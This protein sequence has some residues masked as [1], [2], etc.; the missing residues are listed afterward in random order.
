MKHIRAGSFV[1]C[2]LWCFAAIAACASGGANYP[3]QQPVPRVTTKSPSAEAAK[4]PEL[5]KPAQ[6]QALAAAAVP[7]KPRADIGNGITITEVGGVTT[8]NYPIQIGRPFVQGEIPNFPQAVIDGAPVLTQADVKVRWPDGSVKHAILNFFIPTLRSRSQVLITF[9][10][11][12][13][14]N[15]EGGL[16]KDAMLDPAYDFEAQMKLASESTS[17]AAS[18]RAMLEAGA[19]TTW[20]QGSVATS[21]ILADHSEKRAF[22]IGFDEHRSFRPIFHATFWPTIK[23]VRVRF[24]GEL[25]NTEV[26][27]DQTY[28]LELALGRKSPASVYSKPTFIQWAGSRWT[29]EFWIG[30]APSAIAIDHNLAY[31]VR[32]LM[33]PNYDLS[34]RIPERVLVNEYARWIKSSHDI[35]GSGNW[36]PRMGNAGARADIGPYPSW[37]VRW[38]YTG[39]S[40]MAEMAFG[41]AD[42]AATWPIHFREGKKGKFFDRAKKVPA[43]GKVLSITARPSIHLLTLTANHT[44]R[45]DK[46]TIVGT[47][48]RGDWVPENAHQPD[49]V[50]PQYMLSGDYW[51]LEELYFWAS[52]GAAFPNGAMV[53]S[54]CGRG[55]TG[56][57]GG[58]PGVG[59]G[60][61][62]AQ[63]WVI[64]TRAQTAS[65]APD[66]SPEKEYF[67]TLLSDFIAIAEGQRNITSTKFY[68][69]PNWKWGNTAGN[70]FEKV[71][72]SP[73]HFWENGSGAFVQGLDKT[74]AKS[75]ISTWEQNFM[76]F[77]LARA[78]DLGYPTEALVSWLAPN[79]IGQLTSS[80]YDPYLIGSNRTAT[81]N[82]EDGKPF[83]S[84]SEVRSAIPS[85]F[86]A[87]KDFM[88]RIKNAEHGYPLIA[89]AAVAAAAQEPGGAVAWKWIYD[90]A[91]LPEKSLLDANP[92]WAI[93]P[94]Q[95]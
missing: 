46:I 92:K 8:Q 38:L 35:R 2:V 24:I 1:S 32:T 13:S 55:P 73:L 26:F 42:L 71:G 41:N 28:S 79:I 63:A 82:R 77:A 52:F 20:F 21:I 48:K 14:G 86:D 93:L 39:D 72:P 19:Y 70:P 4:V 84:W 66:N 90:N 78:K 67:E 95:K 83:T 30:G 69:T 75:A 5:P 87:K 22:D 10:N 37:T 33:V 40:R 80:E 7:Q 61:I 50:S 74:K 81:V 49:P 3:A 23:K 51:Y 47:T 17:L 12:T 56:A 16:S 65:L 54:G 57:E 15:N 88:A 60:A 27:Q 53:E 31:L 64:R 85:N 6:E 9:R 34:H 29:K 18:A 89:I 43:L 76:L 91:I 68:D 45:D 94:R 58:L 36:S 62:R 11:Q 59:C 25:A 44:R